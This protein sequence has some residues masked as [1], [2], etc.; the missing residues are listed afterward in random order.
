MA[1]FSVP[2]C[3]GSIFREI[4]F[5][6]FSILYYRFL[7]WQLY[8]SVSAF[9]LVLCF[10]F[11]ISKVLGGVEKKAAPILGP[12]PVHRDGGDFEG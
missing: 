8:I 4:C 12:P 6:L 3:L 11:F 5:I 2:L 7:I 9:S 10:F 1:L